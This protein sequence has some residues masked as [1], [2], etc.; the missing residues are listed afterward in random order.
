MERIIYGGIKKRGGKRGKQREKTSAKGIKGG[1]R[2]SKS[3]KLVVRQIKEIETAP[4][5]RDKAKYFSN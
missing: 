5:V 1:E 2:D 4:Q 3:N